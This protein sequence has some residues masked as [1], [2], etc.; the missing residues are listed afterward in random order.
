MILNNINNI[1]SLIDNDKMIASSDVDFQKDYEV[2]ALSKENCDDIFGIV[3]IEK[4]AKQKF[5]NV[6]NDDYE[7]DS[8]WQMLSDEYKKRGFIQ[9]VKEILELN[10][11]KLFTVDDLTHVIDIAVQ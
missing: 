2:K 3:N 7:Y 10:K 1:Y 4:L 11:D 9:G 5:P 8:E 6:D